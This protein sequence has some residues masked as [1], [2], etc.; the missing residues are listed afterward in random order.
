MCQLRINPLAKQDLFDI[1]EYITKE[2]DNPGAGV[3][4]IE[5][6]MGCYEKLK[7]F[8]MLGI[9]LSSKMDVPTDYRYLICGNYL[10]FYK[11]D[12]VFVSIYRILYSKRDYIKILLGEEKGEMNSE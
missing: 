8:P 10:V 3:D 9:E 2:L 6:I 7:G 5:N 1:R 4:T 11:L 12:K